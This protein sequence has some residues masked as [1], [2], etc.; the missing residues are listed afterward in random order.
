M[1]SQSYKVAKSQSWKVIKFKVKSFLIRW[2]QNAIF[3]DSILISQYSY[4]SAY[5]SLNGSQKTSL[6]F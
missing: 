6:K 5:N 2:E 4:L 3:L 1:N